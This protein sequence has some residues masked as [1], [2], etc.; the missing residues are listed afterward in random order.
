MS[1]VEH[2][3]ATSRRSLLSSLPAALLGSRD[4]TPTTA[5]VASPDAGLIS[6]CGEYIAL[7]REFYTL[8]GQMADLP[9]DAFR[10]E[11]L[12]GHMTGLREEAMMIH[13]TVD[14]ART[15]QAAGLE[16]IEENGGGPEARLATR[17]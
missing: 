6:L 13:L 4:V 16:F 9:A 11:A 2:I 17:S 15:A 5:M 1:E 12:H 10:S 7:D 8:S 14:D 3:P